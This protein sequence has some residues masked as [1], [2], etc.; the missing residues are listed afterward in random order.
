MR[1]AERRRWCLALLGPCLWLAASTLP[2][3]GGIAEHQYRCRGRVYTGHFDDCF[4]DYLPILEMVAPV[5]ALLLAYPFARF[6]FSLYAP[7]VEQRRAR[8][9]LATK[10]DPAGLWPPLHAFAAIGV[11]WCLWRAV[12]YRAAREFLPFRLFWTAFGLWFAAGLVA[13]LPSAK[14]R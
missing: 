14:E 8:W 5:L 7:P 13:A 2:M 12:T 9:R 10:G 1:L 3:I 11:M 4:N 6:A